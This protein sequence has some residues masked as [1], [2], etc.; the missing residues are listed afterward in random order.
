LLYFT[1]NGFSLVAL[2]RPVGPTVDFEQTD[3]VRIDLSYKINDLTQIPIGALEIAAIRNW[4][5]KTFAYP[6]SVT[7]VVQKKSHFTS[8][9]DLDSTG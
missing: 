9:L 7:D 4:E 6:C 2:L 3:D 8:V 1:G 5:V